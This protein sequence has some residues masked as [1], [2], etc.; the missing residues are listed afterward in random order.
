[1]SLNVNHWATCLMLRVVIVFETVSYHRLCGYCFFF[2]KVLIDFF[3]LFIAGYSHIVH[4]TFQRNKHNN[5]GK[6]SAKARGTLTH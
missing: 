3:G 6:K 4:K 5:I 2:D 1:M